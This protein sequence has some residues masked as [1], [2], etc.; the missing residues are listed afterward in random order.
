[1]QHSLHKISCIK[2]TIYD[3]PFA[4]G[5]D[6]IDLFFN[7]VTTCIN[8]TLWRWILAISKSLLQRIFFSK[9]I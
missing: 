4:P 5:E 6:N 2:N 8:G 7:A 9:N 3:M 1:M